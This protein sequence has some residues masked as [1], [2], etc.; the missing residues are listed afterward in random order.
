MHFACPEV[1]FILSPNTREEQ[2]VVFLVRPTANGHCR[3]QHDPQG[4]ELRR[5]SI[6]HH[7][8]VRVSQNIVLEP[9]GWS[10]QSRATKLT[11]W[12]ARLGILKEICSELPCAV[13]NQ[14][15]DEG[16]KTVTSTTLEIYRN[17]NEV[18]MTADTLDAAESLRRRETSEARER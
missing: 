17:V 18:E 6:D 16:K 15:V 12:D 11:S 14:E 8:A 10:V 9:Q 4:L 5:D 3:A 2:I 13:R 1:Q 7:K